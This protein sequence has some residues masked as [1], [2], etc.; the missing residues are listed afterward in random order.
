MTIDHIAT[1]KLL[2]TT[3]SVRKRLDLTREVEPQVIADCID[4]AMQAPT[5]TNAQ[6]WA[7]VVI[8]DPAKKKFIADAY[9]SGGEMM[10]GSGYPP[11]LEPGDPREHVMPKVME[12]AGYLGEI[13]EQVPVFVIACVRGRVESVPMVIAQASTYGSILPAAWSFMLA[14][15]SRGLGTAWT[16][17]HLF[18]EQAI[19]ELLGIPDDW[20]QTVLFPVAYYTGDDF[21]PA[22]RLPSDAMT[23][24]DSWGSHR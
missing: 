20:T 14:L 21:K 22:H 1:D 24:W 23:H 8:T 6:N 10:A 2:T 17:I 13:L 4:I 12:S 19:S 7:F 9:R 3:R 16:T 18:Q 11:P 15:R 5:G